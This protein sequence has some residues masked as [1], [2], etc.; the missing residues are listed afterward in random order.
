LAG[1][2]AESGQAKEWLEQE[3]AEIGVR[4]LRMAIATLDPMPPRKD[5]VWSM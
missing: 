3:D 1:L 5:P 2:W 4:R